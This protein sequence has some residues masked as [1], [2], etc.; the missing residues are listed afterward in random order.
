MPRAPKMMIS[1]AA[2]CLWW[3]RPA[4]WWCRRTPRS[5]PR[6]SFGRTVSTTRPPGTSLVRTA[7]PRRRSAWEARGLLLSVIRARAFLVI[8]R[9]TAP[10]ATR[11]AY[12]T[13]RPPSSLPGSL[14]GV[15]PGRWHVPCRLRRYPYP[16]SV[17]PLSP[18]LFDLMSLG[19][20]FPLT[21]SLP[22]CIGEIDQ[23]VTIIVASWMTN[24]LV[25]S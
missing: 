14:H 18:F 21:G 5:P 25:G 19:S 22:S 23:R 11:H 15:V 20:V 10:P 13:A 16:S 24:P 17:H 7:V 1:P 2:R 3:V 12:H 6:F 8:K 4:P 9:I